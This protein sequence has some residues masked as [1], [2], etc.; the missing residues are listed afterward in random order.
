MQTLIAASLLIG[1][2]IFL[3]IG[4]KMVKRFGDYVDVLLV[5]QSDNLTIRRNLATQ[6]ND[7]AVLEALHHRRHDDP[8]FRE[9]LA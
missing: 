5:A 1:Q 2:G 8:P 4:W 9:E 7:R 3:L 6:E